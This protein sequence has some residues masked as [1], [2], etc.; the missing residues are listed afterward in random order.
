M[1][2]TGCSNQESVHV[3]VLAA[4]WGGTEWK[5]TPTEAVQSPNQSNQLLADTCWVCVMTEKFVRGGCAKQA[6]ARVF[7]RIAQPVCSLVHLSPEPTGT[8]C[9]PDLSKTDCR[10]DNNPVS[11]P[12]PKKQVCCQRNKS[13][14]KDKSC[15]P[16]CH[17]TTSKHQ[18]QHTSPSAA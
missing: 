9:P 12:S 7:C 8:F 1:Q 18:L 11:P 17:I 10:A 3:S 16:A 4:D 13:A 14:A 5:C 2:S 6:W 15:L